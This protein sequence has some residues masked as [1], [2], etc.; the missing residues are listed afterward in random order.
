MISLYVIKAYC[1][2]KKLCEGCVFL[3]HGRCMLQL[4]TDPE[5]WDIK[6][7]QKAYNRLM[8]REV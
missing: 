5:H 1:K 6:K 8:K 3:D 4:G 2:K 7:L